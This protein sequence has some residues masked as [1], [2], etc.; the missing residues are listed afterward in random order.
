MRS[1]AIMRER[2]SDIVERDPYYNPNLSRE[3]ADFS[4]G[5]KDRRLDFMR[6]AFPEA[7]VRFPAKLIDTFD[8][9]GDKDDRH[10]IAAAVRGQANAIV[11]Q[12]IKHFSGKCLEEYG[13]LCQTPDDFLVHQFHL[14]PSLVMEKLDQQGAAINQGRLVVVTKLKVMIPQFAELVRQSY[15]S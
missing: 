14:N 12:N 15:P 6:S 3:R 10:V 1:V 4:L 9:T 7:M 5:K 2:W 8:C 11:T 13:I